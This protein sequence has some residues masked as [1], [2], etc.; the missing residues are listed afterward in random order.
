MLL[1]KYWMSYGLFPIAVHMMT[2]RDLA[3]PHYERKFMCFPCQIK[4]KYYHWV[5]F[6]FILLLGWGNPFIVLSAIVVA[7]IE[8]KLFN[9]QILKL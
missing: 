5:W 4:Q 2:L 8:T 6:L 9:G 7:Y 3:D 1:G